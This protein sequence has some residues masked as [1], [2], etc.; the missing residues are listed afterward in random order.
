M[1]T[2]VR[3]VVTKALRQTFSY[4][5]PRSGALHQTNFAPQLF[6]FNIFYFL[7]N[8]EFGIEQ[9]LHNFKFLNYSST[10]NKIH[11]TDN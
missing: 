11:K 10:E 1:K 7:L 4:L 6:G 9:K 2:D 8:V 3:A 5:V